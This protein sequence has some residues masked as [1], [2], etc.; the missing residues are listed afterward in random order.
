[1][2]T[3]VTLTINPAVDQSS[4]V[5]H[6]VPE[7]KLRCRPPR[8]E[9]GGGGINVSRV[10][11]ELGGQSLALYT[12]GGCTGQLL[13]DLLD[14]TG[15]DHRP[16]RIQGWTR[17][18]LS[19]FEEATGQQFRFNMPGPDLSQEDPAQFLRSLPTVTPKPGYIVGSGRLPP[20]VPADF[21]ARVARIGSDMGA[22]VI[23]DTSGEA[24]RKAVE[25]G[26]FMIKP[27]TNEMNELAG[28]KLRDEVEQE[29]AV[30][31]I[32]RKG[33]AE[34]LVLSLGAAGVLMATKDGCERMRA[35]TVPIQSKVGAGDSMVAGIVLSLSRGRPT[36]DSVLFGLAAGSAAVMTP[37]T[38]LC[39][40]EDVE[41]LYGLLTS[42]DL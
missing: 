13:E 26:V 40:R 34:V 18:S 28:R 3:I 30:M 37:G 36:R 39:R 27:N 8:Y 22:R 15:I 16:T 7:R 25:E 29:A 4:S 31:D 2:E 35:P 23:I 38:E 21:Y 17:V 42:K 10:I 32:L 5:E 14:R 1:M 6:V 33:A 12:A 9:P 41:R 19:I 24:L 11:A 20:G